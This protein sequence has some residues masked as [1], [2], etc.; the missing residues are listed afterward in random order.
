[1]AIHEYF[2][3]VRIELAREVR[4]HPKLT[5]LLAEYDPNDFTEQVAEIAAYCEV[6][7]HGDYLP[8]EIDHLCGI[9]IQ[10]LKAKR[11]VIITSI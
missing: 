6:V 3:E 7:V 5:E 4:H 8:Q 1:M 10:K 11:K 9:L 2:P